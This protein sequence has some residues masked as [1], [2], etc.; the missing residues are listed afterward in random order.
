MVVT[1]SIVTGWSGDP[2]ASTPPSDMLT[3]YEVLDARPFVGVIVK[4]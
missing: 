4:T 3:T 2:D 1:A